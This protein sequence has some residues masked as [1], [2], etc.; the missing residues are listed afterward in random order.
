MQP[1]IRL[2]AEREGEDAVAAEAI[3]DCLL[4]L[5][6]I[7]AIPAAQDLGQ[8]LVGGSATVGQAAAQMPVEALA[9]TLPKL[10]DERRLPHAGLSEDRDQV[11]LA[12]AED[13][14]V[15]EL[16]QVE[17]GA[18]ADENAPARRHTARSV[19]RQR[20]QEPVGAHAVLAALRRDHVQL[21]ELEAA[22]GGRRGPLSYEDVAC[23]RALYETRRDDDW[24]A[25]H[26]P[27]GNGVARYYL[28]GVDAG[29]HCDPHT[30]VALELIVEHAERVAQVE[31]RPQRARRVVLVHARDAENSH[32][33]VPYELV[34]RSA[35]ANDDVHGGIEELAQHALEPLGIELRRERARPDDV[36]EEHGNDLAGRRLEAGLSLRLCPRRRSRRRGDPKRRSAQ[37]RVLRQDR[38]FE[39]AQRRARLDAQLVGQRAPRVLICRQRLRLPAGP[40]Q[41]PHQLAAQPLAQRV[42]ANERLELADQLGGAPTR[43]V[44]LEA[45]L[46]RKHAQL[47][48]PRNLTLRERRVG[49]IR[50][51]RATPETE[52]LPQQPPRRLRIAL[53]ERRPAL[54]GQTLEPARVDL[55]AGDSEA[56]AAALRHHGALREHLAQPRHT[57]LQRVDA[58]QRRSLPPELVD[59]AIAG[60]DLA[61]A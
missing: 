29:A 8:R 52:C 26:Q 25:G 36:A 20:A 19:P 50:K 24:V 17:L 33:L 34:D 37:R 30:P 61:R 39:V 2:M 53:R 47:L 13:A 60:N 35:M 45:I 6:V 31:R 14:L 5:G 7:Q 3:E 4:G 11:R 44:G 49:E 54:A 12:A 41:R 59:Q 27:A 48:E 18:P 51:R 1:R 40:V 22:G 38:A 28:T 56:V 15:R 21:T 42:G 55:L 16:Q 9:K 46:D 32:H 58:G 43:E 57:H 23:L 10:A